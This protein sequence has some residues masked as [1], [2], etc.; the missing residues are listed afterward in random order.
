MA[1]LAEIY[2]TKEKINEIVKHLKSLP[3]DTKGCGITISI[4][5]QANEYNQNVSCYISQTKE[6]REAKE[7]RTYVANGKVFWT[8]GKIA[9]IETQPQNANHTATP[10]PASDKDDL[11]F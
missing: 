1:S 10:V 8:D 2:L 6:Q 11:P 4:N 7:N 9:K 3:P 5:D